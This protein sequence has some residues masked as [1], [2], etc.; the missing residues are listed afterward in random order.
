MS[1]AINR[2]RGEFVVMRRYNVKE[3]KTIQND[4]QNEPALQ[5]IPNERMNGRTEDEARPDIQA[6]GIFR[7]NAFIDIRLKNVNADSQKNQTVEPILKKHGKEKKRAYN[8][9]TMNVE[10][11]SFTPLVLHLTG[12]EG[13]EASMFHK[14]IAQ[15]ILLK[16]KRIAT[17]CSL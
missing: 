17:E 14:H 9:R 6:R 2:E 8:N 5:Q 10:H 3:L 12:S 11:G 7:Q 1:Y 13:P 15:E 4:V 16:S